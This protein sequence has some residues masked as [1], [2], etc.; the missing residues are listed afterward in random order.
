MMTTSTSREPPHVR[1]AL[2]LAAGMGRRLMPLTATRPKCLLEI[3][4]WP[5]LHQLLYGLRSAG[6]DE[7]V[8]VVGYRREMIQA[9][10]PAFKLAPSSLRW[11]V[12]PEYRSTNTLASVAAAAHELRGEPF[13][14]LN[15]DLWI[16]PH[17]LDPLV[18]RA[19]GTAMLVDRS[20]PL[21]HEA[22]KVI[23][24]SRGRVCRLGKRLPIP[25]S[26]GESIGA[27]RFDADGGARFLDA[28][29]TRAAAGDDQS[30]YE[31]A[32]DDLAAHGLRPAA[33]D[34]P[35]NTWA[36][37]DDA[38]DLARAKALSPQPLRATG[39]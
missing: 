11:V 3:G 32:L 14:L 27:Y 36:E 23:L 17:A 21:D 7:W 39:S 30:F 37:I 29:V 13:L 34:V 2:I 20:V 24:D 25:A 28:V 9:A 18:R 35:P 1:R 22:M 31:A 33:V 19:H 4:G 10:V 16:Q 6:I 8:I 26:A 38:R 15:G 5:L 12:N